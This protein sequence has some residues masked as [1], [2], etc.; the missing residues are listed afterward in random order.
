MNQTLLD[1][2]WNKAKARQ[3]VSPGEGEPDDLHDVSI[4]CQNDGYD[5]MILRILIEGCPEWHYQRKSPDGLWCS[6]TDCGG[7]R[8]GSGQVL[9]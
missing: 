9:S 6:V 8:E 5:C 2:L 7:C 1:Q 4:G 3:S